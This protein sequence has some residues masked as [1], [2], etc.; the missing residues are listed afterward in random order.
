MINGGKCM[1]GDG[2]IM[3]CNHP[4]AREYEKKRVRRKPR[5]QTLC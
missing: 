2:L 1:C 5:K 3:L 4:E